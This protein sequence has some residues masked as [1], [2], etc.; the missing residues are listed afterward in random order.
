MVG[1]HVVAT[2][3]VGKLSLYERAVSGRTIADARKGTRTVDYALEGMHETAIYD[4]ELLEPGMSFGGPAI[5]EESGTT[6]VVH[7]EDRVTIDTFGNVHIKI[8]RHG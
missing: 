3:E 2:A 1:V 4:G 7:P 5:V 8:G 6:I